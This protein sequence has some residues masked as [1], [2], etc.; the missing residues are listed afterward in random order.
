MERG[1]LYYPESGYPCTPSEV[2]TGK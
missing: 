2:P 1:T